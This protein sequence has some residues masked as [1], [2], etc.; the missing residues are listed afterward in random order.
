MIRV[1][2]SL[3]IGGALWLGACGGTAEP[4]V[5]NGAFDSSGGTGGA[6][7]A[8]ARVPMSGGGMSSA[9]TT[10]A[11]GAVDCNALNDEIDAAYKAARACDPSAAV[12]ECTDA[13]VPA[14]GCETAV[15][16]NP[17]NADAVARF[18]AANQALVD[19][20]CPLPPGGAC[21]P[22]VSGRCSPDNQCY[23]VPAGI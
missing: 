18:T 10:G 8:G 13:V 1:K 11:A 9:G 12:D 3:L 4:G 15:Y 7:G 6:A 21:L 2:R 14:G 22:A 5:N 20:R 17:A 19:G 23:G 16:L